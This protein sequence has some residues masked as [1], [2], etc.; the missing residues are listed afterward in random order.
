[1]K[2][3]KILITGG[4]GS[5]GTKFIDKLLNSKAKIDRLVVFSRDEL[6]QLK[7]K[8]IY[9]VEKYP[10]IRFFLGDVRDKER[11]Y[12]AFNNIDLVIHAAALKQV[13]TAEYN[14]MEF[15]K[16]NIIGASNVIEAAIDQ[17]VK[18][19]V[20]LS[21]D[22]ACAPINLYGATKLC[23]DKLFIAANNYTGKKIIFSVVRY[24]N[25]MGSRGS[26]LPLFLKQ[27]N[28]GIFTITHKEMTRFN[29]T[30]EES[31]NFVLKICDLSIG[32]E[33]FIPKIP[34]F[35][36]TDLAKA[37]SSSNKLKIIGIRP[38]EKMHEEM[39]TNSD[40]QDAVELKDFY[41]LCPPGDKKIKDYYKKKYN[42]KL[43]KENFSYNSKD[44][45][46]YLSVKELKK[47]IN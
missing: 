27:K 35:K 30:L 5:F 8:E 24:G 10:M 37:I 9:P 17:K 4:T 36:V 33:I 14:P 20:A 46:K 11:L 19:V 47:I 6:K 2:Y 29:I 12:R 18:K 32:Y 34:S 3:K 39:I 38:G 1:M 41:V 22:K 16:T 44:N 15:I 26:I 23:S 40:S 13:P 28:N 42:G 31:V 7:L 21:T 43:I 25:V 45:Q